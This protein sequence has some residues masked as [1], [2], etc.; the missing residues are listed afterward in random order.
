LV[1]FEHSF[2]YG[3]LEFGPALGLARIVDGGL[4]DGYAEASLSGPNGS[5]DIVG[6]TINLVTG[7]LLDVA[8]SGGDAVYTHAAGGSISFNFEILLSDASIHQ[9]AFAAPLDSFIIYAD[10]FGGGGNT[11]GDVGPGL[12][13][14]ATAKLLGIR[15]QTLFSPGAAWLWLDSYDS[16]PAPYR[17]AQSFGS[18][19]IIATAPEPAMWWLLTIG[20]STVAFRFRRRVGQ[21]ARLSATASSHR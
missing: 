17:V 5:F 6:G 15:P 12:F 21:R 3:D 2:S 10:S 13:D 9:G 8:P 11:S 1:E 18:T 19:T 16:Y 20:A 4:L 14:S 7:P